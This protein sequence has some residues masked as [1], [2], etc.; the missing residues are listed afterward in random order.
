[1]KR[2]TVMLA[3]CFVLATI[4]ARADTLTGTW[5]VSNIGSDTSLEIMWNNGGTW[6]SDSTI[7]NVN[8]NALGIANAL[9]SGGQDVH[10]KL[11]REAGDYAMD[12]WIGAGKGGGTYVFT[13][14]AAFFDD[15]R[16]EGI[17]VDTPEKQ[18]VFANLDVTR[19]FI[20]D[21]RASG[22]TLDERDLITFR[23]L[24]IDRAYIDS[25]RAAGLGDIPARELISLKALD[26]DAAYIQML[27]GYGYSHL[28]ARQYVTL[29]ALKID[30]AYIKHLADHGINHL[31][32]DELVKY[33][34]LGIN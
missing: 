2:W 5:S 29:K 13:P 19:E 25:M 22:Y 18:L 23:A 26:V 14:N 3:L 34:A 12:G 30:S 17:T 6:H 8:A 32:V 16:K 27:A 21:M 31:T 33:K 11:H 15:L 7:R 28:E 4:V 10:F 9:A 24:D 1:M 20:A